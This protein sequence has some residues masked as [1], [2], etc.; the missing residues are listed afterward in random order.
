MKK[1]LLALIILAAFMLASCAS[2]TCPT[3]SKAPQ[4]K[5]VSKETKI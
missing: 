3:Y 4:A 2:Y 1:T 5:P